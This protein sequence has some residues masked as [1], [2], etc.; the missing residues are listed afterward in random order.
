MFLK[1]FPEGF[2]RK[3]KR[4]WSLIFKFTKI[5]IPPQVFPGSLPNFQNKIFRST[6]GRCLLFLV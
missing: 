3:K 2:I 1:N 4:M 6:F 5:E